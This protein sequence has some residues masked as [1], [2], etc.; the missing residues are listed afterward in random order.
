[1]QERAFAWTRAFKLVL[2]RNMKRSLLSQRSQFNHTQFPS[3]GPSE[4]KKL[5]VTR[6]EAPRFLIGYLPFLAMF[7]L[8]FFG[9]TDVGDGN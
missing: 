9:N 1:M 7:N 2:Q 6:S 4:V 5:I 8:S 3:I